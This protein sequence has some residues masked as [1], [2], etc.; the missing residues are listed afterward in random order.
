MLW[1]GRGHN[2]MRSP[3]E[4]VGR[5]R[6][7]LGIS[8][9]DLGWEDTTSF[10]IPEEDLARS[11]KFIHAARAAGGSVLVHCAQVRVHD[12]VSRSECMNLP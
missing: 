11:A 1:S 4:A 7:E 6:T 12:P 10:A 8:V 2:A 3:Q 5:A 9:L